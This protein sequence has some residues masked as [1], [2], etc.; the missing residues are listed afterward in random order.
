MRRDDSESVVCDSCRDTL[1]DG[2]EYYEMDGATYC[3][4]CFE[5]MTYRMKRYVGDVVDR[6]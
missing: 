3:P 6:F 4:D 1:Y 5:A 2:D